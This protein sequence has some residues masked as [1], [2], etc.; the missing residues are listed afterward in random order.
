LHEIVIDP[1]RLVELQGEQRDETQIREH[2]S[3]GEKRKGSAKSGPAAA[4]DSRRGIVE[5]LCNRR[6]HLSKN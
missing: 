2:P 4:F 6:F 1:L 3:S 5:R